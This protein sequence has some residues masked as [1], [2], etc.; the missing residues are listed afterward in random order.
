L[1]VFDAEAPFPMGVAQ[2]G[3]TRSTNVG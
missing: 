3:F 2:L 1:S